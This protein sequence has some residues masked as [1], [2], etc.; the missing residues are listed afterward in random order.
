[1]TSKYLGRMLWVFVLLGQAVMASEPVRVLSMDA[2]H[3]AVCEVLGVLGTR[4][5]FAT[6]I[7]SRSYEHHWRRFA[8]RISSPADILRISCPACKMPYD[9]KRPVSYGTPH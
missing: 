8:S 5:V 1:M 9:P 2:L 4:R 7:A 3:E 6:S